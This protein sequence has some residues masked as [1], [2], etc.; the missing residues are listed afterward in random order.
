M[1][2]KLQATRASILS[3]CALVTQDQLIGGS[4][5]G[6]AVI[7]WS[8]N[9]VVKWGCG[10][11]EQEYFN[12]LKA[13]QLLDPSIIRV[14]KVLDFFQDHAERGYLVM[15][16]MSGEKKSRIE[17]RQDLEAL[18]RVLQ[19]FTTVRSTTPGPLAGPGPSY[20]L[21]FGESDHPTINS[22]T[23]LKQWLHRRL[24]D[25][26]A[27]LAFSPSNICL[28]HLDLFPR[29]ILWQ[30]GEPPCVLDWLSAGFWPRIF[31]RCSHVIVDDNSVPAVT[32]MPL[33][34]TDCEQVALVVKAWQNTQRYN[35]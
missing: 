20:A 32:G 26:K 21:L 7:K 13:Y 6:N 22:I 10:V 11:F 3:Y 5:H 12:Q 25:E 15:E 8:D 34:S 35:L 23:E 2:G 24:L 18:L 4:L 14:P 31:E 17:D 28:C 30:T 1:V 29:N 19:H 9:I 33:S 16:L 27:S